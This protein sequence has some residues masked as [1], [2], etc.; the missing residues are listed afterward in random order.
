MNNQDLKQR[1]INFYVLG[2]AYAVFYFSRY[3]L[4]TAHPLLKQLIGIPYNSYGAIVGTALFIYGLTVFL[5][6]PLTD[7]FGG[8]KAILAGSAGALVSNIL[9]GSLYFLVDRN[10]VASVG[11][12]FKFGFNLL[13]IV[14]IMTFIWSLNYFFQSFGALAIVKINSAWYSKK[15]RG[16]FSGKFGSVIQLGR[17]LVLLICPWILYSLPW[18][19]VFFIPALFQAIMFFLIWNLVEEHP[20][21]RSHPSIKEAIKAI[22]NAPKREMIVMC[23]FIALLTGMIRNGIEHQISI[24]FTKQFNVE[25]TAIKSYLPYQIYAVLTPFAMILSSLISGPSSDKYFDSRRFPVMTGAFLLTFIGIFSLMFDMKNAFISSVLLVFIMFSIQGVNNILMGTLT[26]DLGGEKV[27]GS[28][29]GMFDGAQYIGGAFISYTLGA[30]LSKTNN[31][32]YWPVVLLVPSTLALVGS[33]LLTK[34]EKNG[35]NFNA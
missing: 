25:A 35:D 4:S 30:V 5:G 11:A 3:N 12:S 15:E 29:T 19:Y 31:W 21:R 20:D 7:I 13:N 22:I 14:S 2:I 9:F 23:I 18:C 26:A 6:G 27:S 17:M 10:I 8:K 32:F 24:F 28:V 16:T 33:T 34:K 1:W